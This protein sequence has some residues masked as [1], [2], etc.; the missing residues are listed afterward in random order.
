MSA[1]EF[2]FSSEPLWIGVAVF[3][4]GTATAAFAPWRRV[5]VGALAVVLLYS[6]WQ[7]ARS[8]AALA[9]V[10]GWSIVTGA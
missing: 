7:M 5:A 1:F 10:G 4:A 2:F 3:V 8:A 6:L 9:A